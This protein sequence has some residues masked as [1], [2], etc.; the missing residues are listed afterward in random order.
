MKN[1]FLNIRFWIALAAMMIVDNSENKWFAAQ[2][3][4][5]ISSVSQATMKGGNPMATLKR[6]GVV[7]TIVL[8]LFVQQG[9]VL[10]SESNYV[11]LDE[12]REQTKFGWHQEYSYKGEVIEV[13]AKVVLP[14]TDKV[15]IVRVKWAHDLM[16]INEPENAVILQADNG[17]GFFAMVESKPGVFWNNVPSGSGESVIYYERSAQA[18][19][20][21][22]SPSDAVDFLYQ[23]VS[24]YLLET[25]SDIRI[26]E[27]LATSRRYAFQKADRSGISLDFQKPLNQ[28]GAYEIVASQ[29]FHGIPLVQLRPQF[30]DVIKTEPVIAEAMGDIEFTIASN[31]DY[32]FYLY[33]AVEDQLLVPSAPLSTFAS[34]QATCEKLIESGYIRNIFDI[35]LEY[36]VMLNPDDVGNTYILLPMWVVSGIIVDNP[37]STTPVYSDEEMA[38]FRANR[39]QTILINAQ[40]A[41]YLNPKDTSKTRWYGSYITW[42][43]V[44]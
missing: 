41:T 44:K 25:G 37:A 24:P 32:G 35:S 16:P 9:S 42:D 17:I 11:T 33:P 27:I 22:L 10:A 4:T 5:N 12:L 19:N 21:P 14:E 38:R 30:T 3:A 20:S 34:V 40:T 1:A 15:P 26:T 23:K 28:M 7:F 29:M 39:H 36:T 18:E 13:D 31:V 8:M 6:W 43:E 2:K